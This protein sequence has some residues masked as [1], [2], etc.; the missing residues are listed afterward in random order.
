MPASQLS[1]SVFVYDYVFPP[2]DVC[3]CEQGLPVPCP[4]IRGTLVTRY[5]HFSFSTLSYKLE[6]KLTT[7][8]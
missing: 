6:A 8:Q 5:L 1:M 7:S 2:A 4:F 3:C